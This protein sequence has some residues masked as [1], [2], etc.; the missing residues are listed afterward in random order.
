MWA[1]C[2]TFWHFNRLYT[3][4]TRRQNFYWSNLTFACDIG[5][6]KIGLILG[7]KSPSTKSIE[8]FFAEIRAQFEE[9]SICSHKRSKHWI[10]K[11]V[12]SAG[13]LLDIGL[14]TYLHRNCNTRFGQGQMIHQI[15]APDFTLWQS[16]QYKQ[17]NLHSL[18][19]FM[20]IC[21]CYNFIGIHLFGSR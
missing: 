13:R 18:V 14:S 15:H 2:E 11:K 9:N 6:E 1:V 3:I 10:G 5:T 16:W 7:T 8:N 12:N 4:Q 19:I 21:H 20:Q 17:A